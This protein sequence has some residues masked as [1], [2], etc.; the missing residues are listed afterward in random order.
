VA[1]QEGRLTRYDQWTIRVKLTY[2]LMTRENK[3]G[4]ARR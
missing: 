1:C 3:K 4:N 2:S